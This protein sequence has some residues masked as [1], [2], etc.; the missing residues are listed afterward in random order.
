MF[1]EEIVEMSLRGCLRTWDNGA[2]LIYPELGIDPAAELSV[3][4]VVC[5]RCAVFFEAKH[6]GDLSMPPCPFCGAEDWRASHLDRGMSGTEPPA[7]DRS[8][9]SIM[10]ILAG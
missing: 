10:P 8:T 6:S 7:V 4:Y 5:G 1:D 3:T 9:V 2:V